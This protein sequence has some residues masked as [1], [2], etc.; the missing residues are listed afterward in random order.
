MN[1]AETRAEHI[2]PALKAAGWG[3][4]EGSRTLREYPIG[5]GRFQGIRVLFK[6]EIA[7]Y[8]LVYSNDKLIETKRR[9]LPQTEGIV[10]VKKLLAKVGIRDVSFEPYHSTSQQQVD[11]DCSFRLASTISVQTRVDC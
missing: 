4:V 9:K 6:P 3:V 10:Q 2:D 5:L 7:E 8:V 11:L 1:E